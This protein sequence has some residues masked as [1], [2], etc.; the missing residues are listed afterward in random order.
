V[1]AF[2]AG[3]HPAHDVAAEDVEDHV[4]VEVSPLGRSL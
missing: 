2:A 3:E 4:E 1:L